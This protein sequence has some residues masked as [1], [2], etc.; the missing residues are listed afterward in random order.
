MS[1]FIPRAPKFSKQNEIL[2]HAKSNPLVKA[3]LSSLPKES[4]EKVEERLKQYIEVLAAGVTQAAAAKVA[5]EDQD[6]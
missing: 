2:Q 6:G 4:Q 5:E 3:L 1:K